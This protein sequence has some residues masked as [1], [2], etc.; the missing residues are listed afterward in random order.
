MSIPILSRLSIKSQGLQYKL[1]IIQGLVFVLPFCLLTYILYIKNAFQDTEHVVAYLLILFVVLAG[2]VTLRQIFDRI[3]KFAQHA[4]QAATGYA[5]VINREALEDGED[6]K[7]ISHSFQTLLDKFQQVG[8]ELTKKTGDLLAIKELTEMADHRLDLS[9]LMQSL[10]DKA[11]EVAK[12]TATAVYYFEKDQPLRI[13]PASGSE[14]REDYHELSYDMECRARLALLEMK[15]SITP[16]DAHT[17]S[18]ISLPVVDEE[19][20]KAILILVRRKI[21]KPFGSE[22]MDSLGIMLNTVKSTIKSAV[23]Y[24][25]SEDQRALLKEKSEFLAA[26]IEKSKAIENSLRQAK[27]KWRRYSFIVNTAKEF[28]TLINRDYRYE[29]VSHSYCHA[30][31]KN[32]EE[33][34]G[35]S[36]HEIWGPGS[37]ELIVKNLDRCFT[38]AEIYYQ[39]KFAF[40]DGVS[41]YYDVNYYPY[42]GLDDDKIT[43]AIV[44]THNVNDYMVNKI[45]LED[46]VAKL[47][48]LMKGIIATISNLIEMKDPYTAGHQ[49]SVANIAYAIAT[50]MNL[51]QEQKELVRISA[52]IHDIGKISIPAEILSKPSKLN[53]MEWALI[54]AHPE[55]AELILS[56]IDFPIPIA[57]VIV[58]HHERIDGSGYPRGLK[59]DEICLEAKII[60]VADVVDSM[61]SHR[62]Y[63]PAVG[64]E[65]AL[66]ELKNNRGILY[67][68]AVVD[69][70]LSLEPEAENHEPRTDP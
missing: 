6:L 29:T 49:Q 48:E 33:I 39:E 61:S 41:R 37:A 59:G 56:K 24:R 9:R 69:A 11:L 12:A 13:M 36:V 68:E 28:M 25:R 16:E 53:E 38:G 8:S 60:A 7:E 32:P 55:M 43:H 20:I 40:N 65:E 19:D 3:F 1:I 35:K 57:P 10:A 62:P 47:R 27:E 63:R 50:A 44:I 54:K 45:D 42:R 34:I 66:E 52:E 70:Y 31:Q 51:T 21:Q 15:S 67:D 2:I 26:E 5:S 58:Q 14:L 18:M 22:D 30:H 17:F 4:E 23:L 64:R 46:T